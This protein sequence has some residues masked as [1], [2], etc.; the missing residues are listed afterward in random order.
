MMERQ[1]NKK[2]RLWINHRTR[3]AV[4]IDERPKSLPLN[5]DRLDNS[6]LQRMD[7]DATHFSLHT[8]IPH[9]RF[10]R[11]ERMDPGF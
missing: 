9:L 10:E 3:Q 1:G 4:S 11:M 7:V 8:S 2:Q 5:P 6:F